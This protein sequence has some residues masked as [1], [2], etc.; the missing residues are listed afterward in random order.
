MLLPD[1]PSSY[2]GDY[3]V[4]Y[5]VPEFVRIRSFSLL[6]KCWRCMTATKLAILGYGK[7]NPQRPRNRLNVLNRVINIT[8]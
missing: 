1:N 5:F 8:L 2:S 3:L 4:N 7:L 6:L